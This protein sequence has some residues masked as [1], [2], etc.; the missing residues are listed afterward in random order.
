MNGLSLIILVRITCRTGSLENGKLVYGT[1]F[2]ITCRT[3]SL[4]NGI[5]AA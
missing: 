4:E 3:G 5:V 2:A 1:D